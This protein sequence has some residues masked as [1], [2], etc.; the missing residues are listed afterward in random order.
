MAKYW[1]VCP[2]RGNDRSRGFTFNHTTIEDQPTINS[3]VPIVHFGRLCV[4]P[5][6][7]QSAILIVFASNS[8]RYWRELDYGLCSIAMSPD[9]FTGQLGNDEINSDFGRPEDK[10]RQDKEHHPPNTCRPFTIQQHSAAK[11]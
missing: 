1:R 4:G 5:F 2:E 8:A 7:K 9:T 3:S 6:I 10:R 11:C